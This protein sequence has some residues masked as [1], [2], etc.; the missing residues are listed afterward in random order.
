MLIKNVIPHSALPNGQSPYILWMVN[1]PSLSTICTFS[2]KAT[3]AIPEKQRDKLS[4]CSITGIHLGLAIGKKA[5]I[6]YD[7]NM[8]KVLKSHNVHF[9]EGGSESECVTIEIPDVGGTR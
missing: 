2:C 4:S 3:I 7:P 9:F 1:K 8:H 6:V 5:F